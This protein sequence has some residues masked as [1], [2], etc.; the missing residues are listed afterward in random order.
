MLELTDEKSA[1]LPGKEVVPAE[2]LILQ[3]WNSYPWTPSYK[4]KIFNFSGRESERLGV[5]Q[6]RTIIPTGSL[7]ARLSLRNLSISKSSHLYDGHNSCGLL[8]ETL[9]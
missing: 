9:Y 6:T 5:L 7:V 4:D 1:S 3:T 2:S 8:M